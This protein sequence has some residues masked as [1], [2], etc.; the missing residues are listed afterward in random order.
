MQSLTISATLGGQTAL[1]LS[2]DISNRGILEKYN[3]SVLGTSISSIQRAEWE[4]K[5]CDDYDDVDE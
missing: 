1:N 5:M 3:V 2:V 4:R